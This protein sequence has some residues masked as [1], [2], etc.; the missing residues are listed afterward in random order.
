DPLHIEVVLNE[1]LS[2]VIEQRR[3]AGQVGEAHVVGRLDDAD[4]EVVGPDTIDEGFGEVLVLRIAEPVHQGLTRVVELGKIDF[5]ATENA[6]DGASW[7]F[8]L[9]LADGL[10]DAGRDFAG[11]DFGKRNDFSGPQILIKLLP[12]LIAAE[13][14]VF[15]A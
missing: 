1:A 6:S 9:L 7:P 2:K 14:G 15:E 11:N 12:Q 10:A 5:L 8:A 13:V 4:V 3:V